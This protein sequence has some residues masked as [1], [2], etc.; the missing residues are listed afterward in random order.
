MSVNK[1]FIAYICDYY[2][3]EQDKLIKRSS[4]YIQSL[5]TKNT[6]LSNSSEDMNFNNLGVFNFIEKKY[7]I[8]IENYEKAIYLH[9]TIAMYNL[10]I[11]YYLIEENIIKALDYCLMAVEHN[12]YIVMNILGIYYYLSNNHSLS[13]KYF[14][15]AVYNGNINALYNLAYFYTYI[16]INYDEAKKYYQIILDS[17]NSIDSYSYINALNNLG[18]YYGNVVCDH[19][20]ACEYYMIAIEKGNKKYVCNPL[21]NLGYYYESIEKDL[22]K[23]IGYYMQAIKYND[24]HCKN[25]LL[26]LTTP[27]KRFLLYKEY[28]IPYNENNEHDEHNESTN[29]H[30]LDN[31]NEEIINEFIDYY[32]DNEEDDEYEDEDDY[33]DDE[34]YDD[35]DNVVKKCRK[36]TNK[37]DILLYE[38]KI[39]NASKI[40]QCP[41]CLIPDKTCII[42]RCFAHFICL[43]CYPELYKKPCPVCRI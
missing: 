40:M 8:A 25:H 34:E 23:A 17:N 28:N 43:D 32:Y 33:D 4:K 18:L 30:N 41:I 14:K 13:E 7:P 26:S 31:D 39:K 11:Y 24:T 1:T 16:N 42:L 5:H 20:K 22:Q 36:C 10:A 2:I 12:D 27:L 21:Y 38:N 35:Y 9:N 37:L 29:N 19:V 6:L 3:Y 15:M